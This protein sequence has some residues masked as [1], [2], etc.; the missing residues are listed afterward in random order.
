ME[1]FYITEVQ[2]THPT[3][4]DTKVIIHRDWA[5]SFKGFTSMTELAKFAKQLGFGYEMVA[6]WDNG[7]LGTCKKYAISHLIDDPWDRS[8]WELAELPTGVQKIPLLENGHTVTCY[9]LNDGTTIH[10]YRPNPNSK[11]VYKLC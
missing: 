5:D 8:F 7:I 4:H 9:F 1:N 10:I 2:R 3:M 6:S 11:E